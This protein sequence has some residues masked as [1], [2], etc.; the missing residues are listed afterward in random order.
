MKKSGSPNVMCRAPASHLLCDVGEYRSFV[1]DADAAVVDDGH[2]AVAA[3]VRAAVARLDVTHHPGVLTR[4]DAGEQV[5]VPVE[6][7]EQVARRDRPA[8]GGGLAPEPDGGFARHL[9]ALDPRDERGVGL[10]REHAVGDAGGHLP[11][12]AV[13]A[14]GK[15]GALR[16]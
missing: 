5:R 3:P 12:E 9:D 11:V 1:D 8:R 6:R 13:A 16:A 10:A 4:A 14:D 7:G 2:G 15:V